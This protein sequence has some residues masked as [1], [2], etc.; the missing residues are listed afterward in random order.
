MN[1][2]NRIALFLIR[3]K[4]TI[5]SAISKKKAAQSA[6]RLFCTPPVRHTGKVI[7][8]FTEADQVT[9]AFREYSIRGFVWNKG[10]QKRA[11]IVHGFQSSVL[12]F[13]MYVQ[14]LISQGYE[15]LA[16]DAPAHGGSSGQRIN[17]LLFRDFILFITRTYGPINAYIAHSFGGL[18]VSLA[19]TT[20]LPAADARL[21]LLA[22]ATETTRAIE[23]FFAM[24]KLK[25][26]AVQ[27]EFE[28]IITE[29]GGHPSSW[30]SVA[31]AV[32][33]MNIP[34]LWVHDKDDAI[35]PIADVE[36]VIQTNQPHIQFM[37][38]EGLGHR[39]I[40]RDHSVINR[41]I[42]FLS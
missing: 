42:Q 8:P 27:R 40:Y 2:V 22:P 29:I 5:L 13:G 19:I 33:T 39:R 9:L 18:A 37:I 30:F 41:V 38:T 15:V 34:V 4:F 26:P 6:F 32:E 1:L 16:F 7:S 10:A 24:V 14:P 17:A 28:Q 20:E 21:V 11:L 35:T 23:H 25:D 12:N 31:R 36:P 3:S